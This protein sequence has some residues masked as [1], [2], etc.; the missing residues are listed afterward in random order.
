MF[1][2]ISSTPGHRLI[3]SGLRK[4][5]K[6]PLLPLNLGTASNVDPAS[7]SGIERNVAMHQLNLPQWLTIKRHSV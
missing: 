7:A 6:T 5:N 4:L 1:D 2:F 3:S